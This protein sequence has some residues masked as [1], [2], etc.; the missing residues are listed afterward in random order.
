VRNGNRW[1][2]YA[3]DANINRV[4]ARRLSD[5]ARAAFDGDYLRQD[6][7]YGYAVTVL[8]AQGVTTDTAHAVLGENTTRAMLYVAMT[9]GRDLN[10]AHP[11]DRGAG[12]AGHSQ[13][14]S[15]HI[16]HRGSSPEAAQLARSIASHG[17]SA[18]T[19]HHVAAEAANCSALARNRSQHHRGI[20]TR[21][22]ED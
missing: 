10:T 19:A 18:R 16:A 21:S 12:D 13:S 8:S 9:R 3:V 5:N 11:Y 7:T 22:R 20:P 1:R 6:I 17:T 14:E 15:V 4:A 2:V